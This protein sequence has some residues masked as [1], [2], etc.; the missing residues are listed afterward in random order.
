MSYDLATRKSEDI[1]ERNF[2]CAIADECHYLKSR[3]TKRSKELMPIYQEAKRCILMSG[4]PMLAR[5]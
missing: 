3:D 1:K 2:Q 5:P 4:T